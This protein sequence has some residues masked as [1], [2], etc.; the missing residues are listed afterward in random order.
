[1]EHNWTMLM[2]K[3]LQNHL[4]S[5]FVA[6]L[7]IDAIYALYPESFCDKNLAIRKVFAFCDSG[8]DQQSYKNISSCVNFSLKQ[9]IS[10][11]NFSRN[12]KLTPLFDK[13]K[14]T[15]SIVLKFCLFISMLTEKRPK[16]FSWNLRCFIVCKKDLQFTHF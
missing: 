14:H 11:Q 2:H 13:F 15:L 5:T 3:I 6:D 1:M 4:L 10:L 7:K 16:S 12:M 8:H 9:C